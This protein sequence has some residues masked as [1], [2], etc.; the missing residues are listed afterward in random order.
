MLQSLLQLL[1]TKF[2]SNVET[3]WHRALGLSAML[4]MVTAQGNELF[5]NGTAAVGL[6]FTRSRMCHNSLHLLTRRQT[7]IGVAT[8]ARMN[9]RLDAALDGQF[10]RFLWIGL[11]GIRRR[12]TVVEI[13]TQLFHFVVMAIFLVARNA[14]IKVVANGTVISRFHLNIKSDSIEGKTDNKN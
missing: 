4:G 7:T 12:R 3:E 6:A 13:E 14:Q 2:L 11:F 8:L 10:A 9:Q 1:L 5:A